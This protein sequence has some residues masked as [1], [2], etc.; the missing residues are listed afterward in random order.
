L[1]AVMRNPTTH[2]AFMAASLIERDLILRIGGLSTGLRFGADSEFMRRAIFA[3]RAVNIPEA[4]YYRRVHPRSL[5]RT[6]ETGFGSPA[7]R[8]VQAQ[9]QA[10]ARANV[11]RAQAGEA[12]DLTP[13][14]PGASAR[15]AHLA[16]PP[17]RRS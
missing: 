15:L 2:P 11:A 8:A 17:L 4:C 9:V 6:P 1:A 16:G 7:R 12:P 5:T 13:I 14:F 3:A 10:L